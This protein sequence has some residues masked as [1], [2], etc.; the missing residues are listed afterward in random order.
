MSQVIRQRTRVQGVLGAEERAGTD[1]VDHAPGVP[2]YFLH[3][4]GEVT[5]L[6]LQVGD[7][8]ALDVQQR[9]GLSVLTLQLTE[10]M[11]LR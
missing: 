8:R 5:D 2:A 3:L 9:G 7:E 4:H 10:A 1:D 6:I 11:L